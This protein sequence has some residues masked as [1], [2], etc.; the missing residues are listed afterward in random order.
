MYENREFDDD[1]PSVEQ[2]EMFLRGTLKPLVAEVAALE[3]RES[4]LLA[5]DDPEQVRAQAH[6]FT[7]LFSLFTNVYMHA[8]IDAH[9]S[10]R[11]S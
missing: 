8:H 1:G 6:Y 9:V 7:R 5:R 3:A 11:K 10:R 2:L 4:L